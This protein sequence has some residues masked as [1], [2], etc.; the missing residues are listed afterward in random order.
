MKYITIPN[1]VTMNGPKGPGDSLG[2]AEFL[3]AN[4]WTSPAW[5]SSG[6]NAAAFGEAF[7][8]LDQAQPGDVVGLSDAVFEIFRPLAVL[9]GQEIN[10]QNA[11]AIM[12]IMAPVFAATTEKPAPALALA[13]DS[14][15]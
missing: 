14:P 5:R 3:R 1:P 4:V 10:G 11:H 6:D 7:A 15:G 9:E 8:A 12:A 2:F 13:D